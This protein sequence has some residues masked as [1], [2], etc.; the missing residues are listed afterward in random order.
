MATPKKK[1]PAPKAFGGFDPELLEF[2]T[3]LEKNNDKK[4]FDAHRAEYEALYL[5]PAKR[6]TEAMGPGLRKISRHLRAEPRVN[7]SIMR[8]QPRY[9]LL[10]GQDAVQDRALPALHRRR[11]SHEGRCRV[12]PP[13]EC[14]RQ[15]E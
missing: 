5:E 3:D 4:W 10:Q 12:R 7:G 14:H 13:S 9:P 11:G 1:T 2:L 6:F 15:S 8:Y